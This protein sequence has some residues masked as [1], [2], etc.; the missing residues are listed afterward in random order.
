M[1]NPNDMFIVDRIKSIGYALK[2]MW[3]LFSSENSIKV[4][5]CLS[6]G[7]MILGYIMGISATE[8]MFQIIA[9]ALV[10]ATEGMN[11]AVEKVANFIEPNFDNKIGEI[12]DVAAG[13][14]AI[15]SL[16]A[17]AIGLVI[18]IPKFLA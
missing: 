10:I 7:V 3:I 16:A 5:T 6:I 4:Q 18:Y 12:K 13:A 2:G 11:T 15:A 17:I 1:K 9:V 8:W 14:V